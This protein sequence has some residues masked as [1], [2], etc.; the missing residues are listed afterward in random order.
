MSYGAIEI[1]RYVVSYFYKND[2]PITHL[3]LQKLLYFLWIDYY[4]KKHEYLFSDDVC[5]WKLGPVVP[6]VYN[7]FCM[8]SSIPINTEYDTSIE[9]TD[10]ALIDEILKKWGRYSASC[11]VDKTHESGS[12]WSEVYRMGKGSGNVIPF[13]LMKE[14]I[15]NHA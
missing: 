9:E 13:D 3:K 4:K 15:E 11:L 6:V 2:D 14:D 5:A 12:V 7:E 10:K 1:A 8:Y